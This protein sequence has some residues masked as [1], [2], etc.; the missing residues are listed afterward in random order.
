MASQGTG[1]S[2]ISASDSLTERSKIVFDTNDSFLNNAGLVKLIPRRHN[3]CVSQDP[4]KDLESIRTN[5]I[6]EIEDLLS[7]CENDTEEGFD[8]VSFQ[9]RLNDLKSTVIPATLSE[10]EFTQLIKT[11]FPDVFE[12][13]ED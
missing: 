6:G 8:L 13:M 5:L 9:D 11:E 1:T 4:P 12:K 7:L 2:T 3:Q 10:D